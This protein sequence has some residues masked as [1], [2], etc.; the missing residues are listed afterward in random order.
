M[1]RYIYTAKTDPTKTI[2][3]EIEAES[4]QDAINKLNSLGY[5]PVSLQ[6]E[7]LAFG[8][9]GML[10]FFK[11]T[12]KEIV[13][14]TRQLATLIESGVNVLN[15]LDIA[16]KQLPNKFLR[17]VINDVAAKIKDG[18]SLSEGLHEYPKIFPEFYTSLIHSGEAG[19]NIESALKRLADFMES[20]EE[21]KDSIRAALTY[22]VFILGVSV[23]TIIALLGFVI[24]RLV[25]MFEDMGQA[26]P[27]PTKILINTSGFL[28]NY[29][30]LF[31]AFVVMAVFLLRRVYKSERGRIAMDG[32]KLKLPVLKDIV[33]K[34]DIGIMARTLSLLISSGMPIVYSLEV[35]SSVMSNQLLKNEVSGFKNEISAGASFS[36]CLTNSKLFP[37]FVTNIVTIGE[38]TGTLE[39]SL[40]RI[41]DDY[42]RDVDRNLKSLTRLLEPVI[43][44]VMGLIVGFIVLS[45]LLP[46]F[47]INL[48]AR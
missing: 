15:G 13:I 41:A 20:E 18:K 27:L 28:R 11:V 10:R 3:G 4:Q 9:Q 46:I 36:K 32:L 39:K 44:L 17:S 23:L 47:Q 26:L 14:F 6:L 8:K 1:P 38:E 40:L 24:P 22:P 45:M 35:S 34:S 25:S 21:F 33:L 29:W 5:F 16:A 43:I 30:W 7:D 37:G 42:E 12:N 31:A 19:G 2:H 48:I